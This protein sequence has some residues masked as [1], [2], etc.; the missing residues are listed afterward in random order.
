M[1]DPELCNERAPTST[2][3]LR[4]QLRREHT[5][6]PNET[7]HFAEYPGGW[8]KW[9]E[10]SG[11]LASSSA[12]AT[13]LAAS[14]TDAEFTDAVTQVP[15]YAMPDDTIGGWIV[16]TAPL[17][18]SQLPSAEGGRQLGDFLTEELAR[19]VARLHNARL[20]ASASRATRDRRLD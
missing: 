8:L 6:I 3:E 13:Q 12:P 16:A 11:S 5:A 19:Y 9:S 2:R 7:M 1:T 17:P 18:A 4:C 10:E 15:W 14:R 20:N